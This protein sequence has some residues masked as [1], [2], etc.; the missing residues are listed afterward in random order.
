MASAQL[1]SSLKREGLAQVWN[2]LDEWMEYE[3][4]VKEK[5]F[6][7]QKEVKVSIKKKKKNGIRQF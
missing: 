2:K 6:V 4:P 1:F 7:P 3:R 5:S